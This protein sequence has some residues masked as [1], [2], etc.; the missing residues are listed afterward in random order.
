MGR[1]D[2]RWLNRANNN[3]TRSKLNTLIYSRAGFSRWEAWVP[4]VLAWWVTGWEHN[5]LDERI[6]Y[7]TKL[8]ST[9]I[10]Q[11]SLW[12]TVF[13]TWDTESR[14]CCKRSFLKITI[15]RDCRWELASGQAVTY[16]H[17]LDQETQ[18]SVTFL[19]HDKAG[20]KTQTDCIEWG[21]Q[22]YV[23]RAIIDHNNAQ[24][25]YQYIDYAL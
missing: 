9:P 5:T 23:T 13:Q 17:I 22:D 10:I 15:P 21:K 6:K 11:C 3:D 4:H 14:N 20:H 18:R 2:G 1:H 7:E 24:H 8:N 19:R 25:G 12:T 16:L